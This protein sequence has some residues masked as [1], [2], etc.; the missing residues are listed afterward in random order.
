MSAVGDRSS[1]P[2]C[3]VSDGCSSSR[4][5]PWSREETSLRS[6]SGRLEEMDRLGVMIHASDPQTALV[7]NRSTH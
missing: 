4:S 1:K 7:L 6:D 5:G 2:N 3:S